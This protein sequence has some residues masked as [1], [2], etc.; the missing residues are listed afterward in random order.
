MIGETIKTLEIEGEYISRHDVRSSIQNKLGLGKKNVHDKRAQ[1]VVDMMFNARET[2]KEPLSDTMLFDWHIMLLSS[3]YQ[4]NLQI[5]SFRTHDEPTQ[6]VSQRSE[7]WIVHYEA[8]PSQNVPEEMSAFIRWFNE[9]APGQPGAIEF[10][11]VIAAIAHLYLESINPFEDGNGRIGRTIVEKA[12]SQ[13]YGRPLLISL[14]QSIESDKKAYYK[15]L[16]TASFSNEITDWIDYFIDII[17]NTQ[18]E[19]ETQVRFIL[20]KA[21]FFDKYKSELN[22]RELKVVNRMVH[23]S[24]RNLSLRD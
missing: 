18:N 23:E 20:N 16:N 6:V 7:K 5:C 9:T 10:A 12:L 21:T 19:S 3:S 15:S 1:G 11:S 17:L 13:G 24:A 2:Y 4:A 8:P 22:D 14:S